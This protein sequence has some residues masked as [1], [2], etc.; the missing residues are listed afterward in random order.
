MSMI[1]S[2]CIFQE[3][4]MLFRES[5]SH[6][7]KNSCVESLLVI[8]SLSFQESTGLVL[9]FSLFQRAIIYTLYPELLT[10]NMYRVARKMTGKSF[11]IQEKILKLYISA[12]MRKCQ[13]KTAH[14]CQHQQNHSLEMLKSM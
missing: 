5:I 13:P 9:H 6:N 2:I 7:S 8:L 4:F 14:A 11:H 1:L 12:L 10:L 3:N